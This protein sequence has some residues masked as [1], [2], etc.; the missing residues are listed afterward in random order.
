M[1]NKILFLTTVESKNKTKYNYI[2]FTVLTFQIFTLRAPSARTFALNPCQLTANKTF[3]SFLIV[4]CG[5]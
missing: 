3:F 2:T 1:F 4:A 5:T